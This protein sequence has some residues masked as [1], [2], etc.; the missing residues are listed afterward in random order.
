MSRDLPN[1]GLKG[2]YNIGEDDWGD[3]Q[4]AN[5]LKLSV[6]VQG[7][8]TEIAPDVP[9]TPTPGT[10]LILDETNATNPNAVAVFEGPVG[11]EAW[12]YF[13]PAPGWLLWD[14]DQAA[15]VTFDG[16]AW[17]VLE[18]GGGGA[19]YPDFAGN[20]GK[21]L[22]VNDEEDGVEWV[23]AG[24]ASGATLLVG[25]PPAVRGSQTFYSSGGATFNVPLPALAVAGDVALL[26]AGQG[27]APGQTTGH[28]IMRIVVANGTNVGV[29]RRVLDATDI[30]NGYLTA[31]FSGGF[32][33]VGMVVVYE[34]GQD[35]SFD[36]LDSAQYPTAL[37]AALL[38]N[39]PWLSPAAR[40]AGSMLTYL[41]S[42]QNAVITSDAG[43]LLQQ[44]N[45]SAASAALY[46]INVEEGDQVEQTINVPSNDYDTIFISIVASAITEAVISAESSGPAGVLVLRKAADQSI[47]TGAWRDVTWDAIAADTMNAYGT[48]GDT[49]FVVPEGM[50]VMEVNL[51]ATWSG[52]GPKYL[53]LFNVTDAAAESVVMQPGLAESGQTLNTGL[54]PVT[55]GESY[56]IQANS[57]T[58]T[59]NLVGPGFGGVTALTVRFYESYDKAVGGFGGGSGGGSA[60]YP[61]GGSTG[62]LLA[63]ASPA[64]NDVEWVDPPAGGGGG[65]SAGNVVAKAK[66]EFSNTGAMTLVGDENIA[67]VTRTGAGLYTVEFTNPIPA[68]CV[69]GA[70]SGR[71][72]DNVST[73]EGLLIGLS[74]LAGEGVTTA[75]ARLT[76]HA[77]LVAGLF[78]PYES[79]SDNSWIYF[80]IVDPTVASS[81][82]GGSGHGWWWDPP[83]AADFT[84]F[85][86]YLGN[87]SLPTFADDEDV[88]LLISCPIDG[89]GTG[90][91]DKARFYLKPIP[92]PGANWSVEWYMNPENRYPGEYPMLH[93]I[94]L[95]DAA[96]TKRTEYGWDMRSMVY[97]GR[98]NNPSGYGG[99]EQQQVW[100]KG[101][102][103]FWKVEHV[104]VGALLNFYASENG[105]VWT[106]IRSTSDT[107]W[108]GETPKF[109][110]LGLRTGNTNVGYTSSFTVEMWK[111]TGFD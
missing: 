5:L 42:R 8:V 74:R 33:G 100:A 31:T 62:Q 1:L 78:D 103:R 97:W 108:L 82:G 57:G 18:T 96:K 26:I 19:D 80:E 69:L 17:A 63:K 23:G 27:Y 2:G 37:R 61:P 48:V 21:V 91:A 46:T 85:G 79:A 110:G 104:A 50:T 75:E 29:Y 58:T 54:I 64:D 39:K 60:S 99:S 76:I 55:P 30:A 9:G 86:D 35:L 90:T 7:G 111:E 92:N 11:E 71:F 32:A 36:I 14:N 40:R 89:S 67:S 4:N 73:Q 28:D 16:T 38:G 51:R 12:S 98:F 93:G 45:G 66:V 52:D 84:G 65:G 6:L 34:G 43:T 25:T 68:G 95:V 101:A 72:G 106:L 83:L 94:C 20:A 105:K 41:Y 53:A 107:D 10:V 13:E 24:G 15:Y 81:G 47:A 77:A 56:R 3:D 70:T 88:G 49:D 109:I 102:P 22:A 59:R 87:A 44:T